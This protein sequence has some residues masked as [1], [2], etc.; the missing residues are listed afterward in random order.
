MTFAVR[1][2]R[3]AGIAMPTHSACPAAGTPLYQYLV[4][5][6]WES[7]NVPLGPLKYLSLIDPDPADGLLQKLAQASNIYCRWYRCHSMDA[8]RS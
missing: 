3:Q 7:W 4:K 6:L 8:P 1:D 2:F 5:R